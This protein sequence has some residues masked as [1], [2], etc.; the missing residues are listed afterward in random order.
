V[1]L[2]ALSDYVCVSKYAHFNEKEGRRETWEESTKRMCDMH[3]KKYGSAVDG[4]IDDIEQAI[5][6]KRILPSMRAMQFGSVDLIGRGQ[7]QKIYNCSFSYCDRV[8]F[9]GECMMN[10]LCGSGTGFG[11]KRE[12][13]AKLP[14]IY[15]PRKETAT[16]T[17]PDTIE[18]WADAVQICVEQYFEP[19]HPRI[20]FDFSQIRPKGA[21][22]SSGVGRAPGPAG[23][24]T[25][26]MRINGVFMACL[27]RGQE[28]LRP[29][30]A[31]D[32][33]MHAS[34]AVLSG[35]VRRSASICLFSPDDE[36]MLN[37]KTG[38]W[39]NENP[40]R[41]RSNNSAIL[42][43]GQDEEKFWGM[44]EAVK[45][46]GEPGFLWVDDITH[47]TNPCVE[48]GLRGYDE[49]GNSGWQFCNLS[50][51]NMAKVTTQ[52]EFHEACYLAAAVGTL[53]AGY[54]EFDY[55]GPVSER[56]TRREALIGVSMTGMAESRIAK[57]PQLLS[58]GARQVKRANDYVARLI[59]INPAART[60]C[61]KPEG[62]ASAVLQTSSG[63]HP[64]HHRRA[65]RRVQANATEPVIAH[66][67]KGNPDA[68]ESSV[69]G[70]EDLI[71]EFP[72]EVADG[73]M[74]KAD[75]D[76]LQ[77][78]NHV[79]DVKRY[80]VDEGRNED[81]CVDPR[82]SHNV[83]NTINVHPA[84]WD[85]VFDFIHDMREHLS[86]V[87]LLSASGDLDYPQAPFVAVWTEE[88]IRAEYGDTM[89]DFAKTAI[90][91]IETSHPPANLLHECVMRLELLRRYEELKAKWQDVDYREMK[92]DDD[93]GIKLSGT[94]ACAGGSCEVL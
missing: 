12:D 85:D 39:F 66:F 49:Y 26:L 23:L 21:K 59:G 53:Q 41:A 3:R 94:V 15:K 82:L 51:I 20:V 67:A 79:V 34:D 33:V 87:S 22:I 4:L 32:V 25:A 93:S 56:I 69:W 84:E 11:V 63:I 14:G 27:S 65:I 40:Q 48:I 91:T 80:W 8:E 75:T 58:A 13:I 44:T 19:D 72:Y 71:A 77:L 74:I 36:E 24:Q 18:G 42:V 9:F 5:I 83:S 7:D 57:R 52:S 92:E 90:D 60:T 43:R 81:L 16:F 28:R 50:T 29:I 68:V 38:N 1:S 6:E 78:L 89:T 46:F 47:G 76:A 2:K 10:L 86:G 70:T 62:T 31:Y 88:E 30:D 73:A 35:G 64:H 37:A 45:Q 55:L 54:T 61:V 17:I